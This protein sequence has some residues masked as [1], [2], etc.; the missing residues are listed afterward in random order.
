MVDIALQRYPISER[1]CLTRKRIQPRLQNI[2]IPLADP[3][4]MRLVCLNDSHRIPSSH[5]DIH[6]DPSC[7]VMVP[8]SSDVC[9]VCDV[10]RSTRSYGSC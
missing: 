8:N 1:I 10:D 9:H 4:R 3:G 7:L 6:F 2:S 5:G